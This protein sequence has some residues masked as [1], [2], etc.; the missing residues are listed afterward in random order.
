M[1][2]KY[3]VLEEEH[4]V[5]KAQLVMEKEAINSQLKTTKEELSSI[6]IE[7]RSLRDTYNNKNDTWIKEK[8]TLEDQVKDLKKKVNAGFPSDSLLIE[9]ARLKSSIEDKTNELDQIKREGAVLEDQ[10]KYLRKENEDL[11]QKLDDF[12]KVSKVQRN[13]T[14]ESTALDKEMLQLKNKSVKRFNNI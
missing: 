14:A 10:I 3:E 1:T 7:L 2:G 4:V 13:M 5:T 11:K 12:D 6:E 9:R 8:L